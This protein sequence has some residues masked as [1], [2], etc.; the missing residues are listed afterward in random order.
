MV[1]TVI[2]GPPCSGKST[3]MH[4]HRRPGDIT[5]DFDDLAQALGS[6]SRHGH[7]DDLRRVTIAAR[8]AAITAAI[9]AHHRGARVWIVDMAPPQSRLDQYER[10][11]A[12]VIK[13]AAAR[14]ELHARA[15]RERPPSWH[16]L[17]DQYLDNGGAA[18]L[19]PWSGRRSSDPRAEPRTAW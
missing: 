4:Q 19:P 16:S 13:L 9:G 12:K 3:Y 7:T 11:G 18:I 5:I 17:I 8:S 1:I 10:A 15:D 14:E 6:G 2:T